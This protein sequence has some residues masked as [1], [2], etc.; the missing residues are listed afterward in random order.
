VM[1]GSERINTEE[2]RGTAVNVFAAVPIRSF[3][4]KY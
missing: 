3:V 4:P 2:Y 1:H